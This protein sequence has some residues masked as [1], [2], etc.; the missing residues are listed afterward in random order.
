MSD[1]HITPLH[2]DG[3]NT[4]VGLRTLDRAHAQKNANASGHTPSNQSKDAR[5]DLDFEMVDEMFCAFDRLLDER[6]KP[7]S[8]PKNQNPSA[9]GR[10]GVVSSYAK[11][12]LARMHPKPV[13][14]LICRLPR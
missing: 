8:D 4:F 11:L 12:W 2:F 14:S 13:Q 1:D 6:R 7:T 3:K 5:S 10:F 9:K